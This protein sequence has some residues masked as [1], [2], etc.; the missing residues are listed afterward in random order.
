MTRRAQ[1]E[2]V[3]TDAFKAFQ[4]DIKARCVEEPVV[5]ELSPVDAY[6]P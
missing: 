4:R 2:Y 6:G 1:L 5:T 3:E